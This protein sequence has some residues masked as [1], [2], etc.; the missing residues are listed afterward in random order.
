MLR[1]PLP[2]S[3]SLRSIIAEQQTAHT[4]KMDGLELCRWGEAANTGTIICETFTNRGFRYPRQRPTHIRK[5]PP[6]R[7]SSLELA[8]AEANRSEA[9]VA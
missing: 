1:D 3:R 9:T 6:E 2:G 5:G 4:E 7:A 8:C